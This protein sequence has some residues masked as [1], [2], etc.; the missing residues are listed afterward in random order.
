MPRQIP[1]DSST[2]AHAHGFDGHVVPISIGIG[3]GATGTRGVALK[4][5]NV[6]H[7]TRPGGLLRRHGRHAR[8]GR[9]S[10]RSMQGQLLVRIGA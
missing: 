3:D 1:M 5:A 8:D 6:N 9:G 10:F 2:R 7:F 4:V